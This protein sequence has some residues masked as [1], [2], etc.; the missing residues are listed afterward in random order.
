MQLLHFQKQA[1]ES[2]LNSRKKLQNQIIMC[3]EVI[4]GGTCL[5]QKAHHQRKLCICNLPSLKNRKEKH[6]TKITMP[7][8]LI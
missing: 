1:K 3:N 7:K 2:K 4:K 6:E 8:I 5:L